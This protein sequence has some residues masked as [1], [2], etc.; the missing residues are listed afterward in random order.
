M[1]IFPT[2]TALDQNIILIGGT[3]SIDVM[4]NV[5]PCAWL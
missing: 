5:K 1:N 3:M 4:V 2:A